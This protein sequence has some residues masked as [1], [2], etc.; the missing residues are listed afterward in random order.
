[1]SS[2]R[3]HVN[4]LNRIRTEFRRLYGDLP[5]EELV[6]NSILIQ[7]IEDLERQLRELLDDERVA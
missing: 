3:L 7:K 5:V 6:R 1:M 4:E 2:K